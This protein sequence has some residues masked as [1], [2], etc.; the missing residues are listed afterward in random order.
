MNSNF[1]NNQINSLIMISNARGS[2]LFA[3]YGRDESPVFKIKAVQTEF[4]KPKLRLTVMEVIY[5]RD[6]YRELD[7]RAAV[8]MAIKDGMAVVKETDT[9]I[10][11]IPEMGQRSIVVEIPEVD[12]ECCKLIVESPVY[13]KGD[14]SQPIRG[15]VDVD[16]NCP[17]R[18]LFYV[19][20]KPRHGVLDL[21]RETGEWVYQSRCEDPERDTFEIIVWNVSGGWATQRTVITCERQPEVIDVNI[22]N[23]PLTIVAEY[24]IDVNVA[25]LPPVVV[26]TEGEALAVD[27]VGMA[28][29][30]IDGA[31]EVT[32]VNVEFP[33][34]MTVTTAV[35]DALTVSV[36]GVPSVTIDG[37]VQVAGIEIS[38]LEISGLELTFPDVMTVTTAEDAPLSV[39]VV[40]VPSVTVEG[41]VEVTGVDV[42][43]PDV[44]TVTTPEDAP[45]SV[46]VVGVPSVTVEGVVEVTGIDVE[47][48]D[49]MT[50]T[51]PEDAPLSVSV[52]GVPTVTIDG[53]VNVAFPD[54]MAVT[55]P[56]DEPLSVSITGVQS[57]TFDGVVTVT[58]ADVYL[59]DLMKVTTP[60][61]TPLS[62]SVT[63]V[64][65]VTIDGFVSVEFPDV[66]TVTTAEDAPLSVSVAGL[67]SVTI[68]GAVTVTGVDVEFPDV[69]TVTTAEDA[70]LSVSV[71]GLPS[72]TI[73]GPVTI[74]G[75][76]ITIPETMMVTTAEDAPLSVS[77]ASLPSVTLD[78]PVTVT[79]LDIT[80]PDIMT[81]TTA[82]N[83]PLSVSV[84]GLP[85]VTIDGPVKISPY[86]LYSVSTDLPEI[87]PNSSEQA[88]FDTAHSIDQTVFVKLPAGVTATI[89]PI[90]VPKGETET[91]ALGDPIEKTSNFAF[92]NTTPASKVGVQVGNPGTTALTG[93][94]V[95]VESHEPI[96][97]G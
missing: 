9:M 61:G 51:T 86:G 67:P 96:T 37:P 45:L 85:S 1:G 66:M 59:P 29:V 26:R 48:P 56:E 53:V 44:M 91:Y 62:V 64:P 50:V 16:G 18:N 63:G 2:H 75:L 21:D 3:K 34:V 27:V 95:T 40:G 11:F 79:G 72:V 42:E 15:R 38:G 71:A 68:D 52:V 6:L 84:T 83:A 65:S 78:G 54:I 39:S 23:T 10:T 35:D 19:C 60:E 73:D 13:V 5:P 31:V 74:T 22:V 87:A 46:S 20:Q 49:V 47:F 77:V 80:I 36:T 55:T 25:T 33:D 32:G 94:R 69:M 41:V 89:Q 97:R 90:V 30:T 81:V 17:A 7:A 43:F 92:T 82:E 70:P 57:V 14:C 58:G 76:D 8:L 24:P 88:L 12:C 93:A 4:A 28:S